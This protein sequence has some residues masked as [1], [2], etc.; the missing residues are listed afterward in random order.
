MSLATV[1]RCA[2]DGCRCS[3]GS[4]RRDRSPGPG[5]SR[6]ASSPTPRRSRTR[7][8]ATSL[9]R[10]TCGALAPRAARDLERS[11][12]AR[13]GARSR[14]PTSGSF[15]SDLDP[16]VPGDTAWQPVDALPRDGVRP[17]GDRARGSRERLRAKLSYTNVGFALAPETFTIS[18]L[19]ELYAAALGHPVSTTNLQRVLVRRGLLEPTGER[20]EP[21]PTGG[22]PA[23]VFRSLAAGSRSPTSP[24]C[25]GRRAA[26]P[27]EPGV[28]PSRARA[29]IRRRTRCRPR[30][31]CRRGRAPRPR[32][33]A[34]GVPDEA[35]ASRRHDPVQRHGHG[36]PVVEVDREPGNDRDPEAGAD[37]P[38]DGAVVVGAEDEVRAGSAERKCDSS[39]STSGRRGSR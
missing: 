2:R 10:S 38:L 16:E 13:S 12:G 31:R 18:E 23:A 22:R 19:R 39:S 28:R 9:R 35:D 37:H 3:C 21:G 30:A 1:L 20:R 6:A 5:R 7:S 33:V 27:P 34:V 29:S 32:A 17:R 24:R 4:G 14:R 36:R 11:D 25:C 8:A 26:A 15:P